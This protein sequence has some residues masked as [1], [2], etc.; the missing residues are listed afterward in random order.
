MNATFTVSNIGDTKPNGTL[1]GLKNALDYQDAGTKV[2]VKLTRYVDK[3]AAVAVVADSYLSGEAI[4][5]NISFEA[6]DDAAQTFSMTLQVDGE[7]T[8]GTNPVI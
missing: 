4:I 7:L 8:V 6:G 3:T 2:T 5:T 1:V